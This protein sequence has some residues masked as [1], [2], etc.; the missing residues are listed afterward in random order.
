MS[1]GFQEQ[2]LQLVY[3][4]EFQENN[5]AYGLRKFFNTQIKYLRSEHKDRLKIQLNFSKVTD[6]RSSK[7]LN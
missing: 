4:F 2:K 7:D 5:G 3:K 6:H 1:R